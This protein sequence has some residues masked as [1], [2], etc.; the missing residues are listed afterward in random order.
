MAVLAD[1]FTA[2]PRTETFRASLAPSLASILDP[3]VLGTSP[4]NTWPRP[5]QSCGFLKPV[6]PELDR[7]ARDPSPLSPETAERFALH[8]ATS[9][10][11]PP[12]LTA[13]PAFQK[14]FTSRPLELARL[15]FISNKAS[16][17]LPPLADSLAS[18]LTPGV[19][20][21]TLELMIRA[22]AGRATPQDADTLADIIVDAPKLPSSSGSLV[23][24]FNP[25]S[26]PLI[27]QY[28]SELLIWN[29]SGN[30]WTDTYA[31]L[32]RTSLLHSLPQS[33][34]LPNPSPL[35]VW[36]QWRPQW[37]VSS[38]EA[39]LTEWAWSQLHQMNQATPERALSIADRLPS[40][41]DRFAFAARCRRTDLLITWCRD[42]SLLKLV[43][44]STL[45][46][47][48]AA[49]N[50]PS[51]A[52]LPEG[53]SANALMAIA[54]E[55]AHRMAL[56]PLDLIRRSSVFYQL[57]PATI[58]QAANALPL[59]PFPPEEPRFSLL[60][61]ARQSPD[62]SQ[63]RLSLPHPFF[64]LQVCPSVERF[65]CIAAWLRMPPTDF[66]SHSHP[67]AVQALKMLLGNDTYSPYDAVLRPQEF[68]DLLAAFPTAHPLRRQILRW[69]ELAR[70]LN[71]D[72][73]LIEQRVSM[74]PGRPANNNFLKA[75][76]TLAEE[77]SVSLPWQFV[78]ASLEEIPATRAALLAAAKARSPLTAGA[79]SDPLPQPPIPPPDPEAVTAATIASAFMKLIADPEV[80]SQ[81]SPPTA[82][83]HLRLHDA[84]HPFRRLLSDASTEAIDEAANLLIN[85]K[86]LLAA[87]MAVILSATVYNTSIDISSRLLTRALASFPDDPE[88]LLA[89]AAAN[90]GKTPEISPTRRAAFIRGLAA[91]DA[92]PSP[93]YNS[94]LST[95]DRTEWCG[96]TD[97]GPSPDADSVRAIVTFT[98][99]VK[100]AH[101]P[102]KWI[103]SMQSFL[104]RRP[105]TDQ[106]TKAEIRAAAVAV[107][108]FKAPWKD[109]Q[110]DPK[111]WLP[112]LNHLDQS[113]AS[114]AAVAAAEALLS[115][116]TGSI[117]RRYWS[118]TLPPPWDRK[119]WPAPISR[120]TDGCQILRIAARHDP[121]ALALR[122]QSIARSRPDDD[123]SAFVT[124]LATGYARPLTAED[125]SLTGLSPAGRHR[126]LSFASWL[127]PPDR[128][129]PALV[130][131]SWE[132]DARNL[133]N[134][135]FDSS[136]FFAA[137]A[138]LDRLANA[139]AIDAAR[140]L[141]PLH[142]AHLPAVVRNSPHDQACI[143][144][145]QRLM[146]LGSREDARTFGSLVT[147]HLI[148]RP[149]M[150]ASHL[151]VLTMQLEMMDPASTSPSPEIDH[152]VTRALASAD[153]ADL[154]KPD[155]PLPAI[156]HFAA[157]H[158]HWHPLL[159][160][161]LASHPQLTQSTHSP[162]PW[163]AIAALLAQLD[164]NT[165]IPGVSLTFS[166]STLGEGS[167]RWSFNGLTPPPVPD[168]DPR[169]GEVPLELPWPNLASQLAGKFNAIV[170]VSDH[171][172]PTSE[173]VAAE[174]TPLP[175]SGSLPLTNLPESARIRLVLIQNDAPRAFAES[176]PIL[177]NSKPT[178]IDSS[179]PPA[180][181]SIH[182][183]GWQ[184]LAD[185]API[186]ASQWQINRDAP[187]SAPWPD[188]LALL[189]LDDSNQVCAIASL[190]NHSP[191][192]AASRTPFPPGIVAL[193]HFTNDPTPAQGTSNLRITGP[194]RRIALAQQSPFPATDLDE[195]TFPPPRTRYTLQEYP[196]APAVAPDGRYDILRAWHL[197][198]SHPGSSDTARP[199]IR[200]SPPQAAWF[201]AH[202]LNILNLTEDSPPRT[203]K[204]NLPRD[205]RLSSIF[206]S[207]P[208][209]HLSFVITSG[210]R[211]FSTLL[212]VK[213]DLSDQA[214]SRHDF[215]S[216]VNIHSLDSVGIPDVWYISSDSIFLG[217]VDASGR[218]LL[219]PPADPADSPASDPLIL[220]PN[221]ALSAS[222]FAC[223]SPRKTSAS[224]KFKIV[225]WSDGSI[226]IRNVDKLP[227]PLDRTTPTIDRPLSPRQGLLVNPSTNP[228]ETW[229]C[230][231]NLTSLIPS[232]SNLAIGLMQSPNSETQSIILLRKSPTPK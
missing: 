27:P 110:G 227:P 78:R 113:G 10:K 55:L 174:I 44:S 152:L 183:H 58:R 204:L 72:R 109:G 47:A 4:D 191:Q 35:T 117:S 188:H 88:L 225:D 13:L 94:D 223:Y 18:S 196:P 220:H 198:A 59:T 126:V 165:I 26:A 221:H 42:A 23:E 9:R 101:L 92:A 160:K 142:N 114:D 123:L 169:R 199:V 8:L 60:D 222:S 185:P 99:R 111:S 197:P 119:N 127:L 3:S 155:G 80:R 67:P 91:L 74:R 131:D 151:L 5:T 62:N 166:P 115:V 192:T 63:S 217:I 136:G 2:D 38:D 34:P 133:F 118:T 161:V 108:T 168:Q 75:V 179:R 139:G 12:D 158:R 132:A 143:S 81:L 43:N 138:N 129:S 105:L 107:T 203:L 85:E 65:R 17:Q 98:E 121:A 147:T 41:A 73:E 93:R 175:A 145:M 130:L 79:D 16:A 124:L 57:V 83:V 24:T 14:T 64:G 148:E 190:S 194:P 70:S 45:M 1:W 193:H 182:P 156:A 52:P 46:T 224:R 71:L 159:R 164:S 20:R 231:L 201:A 230:P 219:T 229:L 181:D 212:T 125:T 172:N 163:L 218:L 140:R 153:L 6:G 176:P 211:S 189:L 210:S 226:S 95:D 180:P 102:Q 90:P 37:P 187:A 48:V 69:N 87:K 25:F 82:L 7:L 104:E 22:W 68:L 30:R 31:S 206:W 177:C 150:T 228:P 184:L 232:T 208:F 215:P 89:F 40:P 76:L 32:C 186:T 135:D 21:R 33:S 11:W 213:A 106:L 19:Q 162:N 134:D 202:H 122:L 66:R 120:G 77:E 53:P 214:V 97:P 200:S 173:R 209:I 195:A 96:I 54:T 171:L 39:S 205:A 112:F 167:L 178:L 137:C 51:A 116:Q 49:F 103:A 141:L 56:H 170:L 86:D 15:L 146:R 100:P 157:G 36:S 149:L 216:E 50:L 84:D 61:L 128:L 154:T 207:G 28:P 29:L 144:I